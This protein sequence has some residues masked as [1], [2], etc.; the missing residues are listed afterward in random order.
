MNQESLRNGAILGGLF[1]LTLATPI[2]SSWF[3]D[4]LSSLIPL[5]MQFLGSFSISVYGAIIGGIAGYIVDK[6]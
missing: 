4:T 3:A 2:I 1:G 6:F 5:S